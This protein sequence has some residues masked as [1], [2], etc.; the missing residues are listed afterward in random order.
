MPSSQRKV[1]RFA[2]G[3]PEQYRSSLWRLWVQGND[4]YLGARIITGVVKLSMHR[5]G[6]WR[7]AFTER[8]GTK[9]DRQGYR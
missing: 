3:S 4:V 6:I 8:S 7:Y 2:V 1:I 5:S 9:L